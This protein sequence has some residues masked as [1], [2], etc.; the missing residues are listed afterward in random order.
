MIRDFRDDRS[1]AGEQDLIALPH[2]LSFSSLTMTASG[3][4]V[5]I[6]G[7]TIHITVENYLVDHEMSD[8][9]SDDPR[10]ALLRPRRPST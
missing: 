6:A 3:N 7:G 10:A 1:P 4:D 2:S 9:G 8:L 5:V